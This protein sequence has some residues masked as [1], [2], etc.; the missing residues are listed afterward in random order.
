MSDL[1]PPPLWLTPKTV[2]HLNDGTPAP[3]MTEL[4]IERRLVDPREKAIRRASEE[5]I[6]A[7][8]LHHPE[9]CGQ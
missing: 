4:T 2:R 9:R 5:L 8:R 6:A 3:R 1:L 7:I